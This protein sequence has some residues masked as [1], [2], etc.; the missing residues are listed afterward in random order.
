MTNDAPTVS[1]VIPSYNC[2]RFIAETLESVVG[3]SYGDLEVIVV[4]DG[5]T[6]GTPEV[7]RRFAPRV[8]LVQQESAGVCAARNRGIAE[9][10]G[11]YVALL[12]HDDYWFPDKLGAQVDVLESHPEVGVV[13]TAFLRWEA[14]TQGVF[15]STMTVDR[16]PYGEGPEAEYSGWI[17][18]LFLL[19]CWMLTSTAMFRAEVFRRCGVFDL[20][21]PYS[22]DWD[23][24]LRIAREYPFVKLRQPGTLY[25]QHASQGNRKVRDRDFR[26]ELLSEAVLKWG[27]C[28]PDGSC[29][30]DR[31][32]RRQWAKYHTDFALGHAVAGNRGVALRSLARALR[33]NPQGLKA[34]TYMAAVAVGWRPRW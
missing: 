25:R 23:L 2:E 18:H 20:S 24:W 21:L 4:D 9:A 33:T 6:D 10:R 19:D 15:P 11:R 30:D 8:R 16:K 34:L 17:Y 28:S 27:L 3:Q 32:F 26:T 29:L 14:D 31:T 12:D 13:F 1:V 22:E 7:V 5:S